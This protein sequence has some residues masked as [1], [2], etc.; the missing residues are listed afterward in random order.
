[1]AAIAGPLLKEQKRCVRFACSSQSN[2]R[3]Q[4]EEK[5]ARQPLCKHGNCGL[6]EAYPDSK[7][8]WHHLGTEFWVIPDP[9][10][11]ASAR[12]THDPV[13]RKSAALQLPELRTS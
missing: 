8:G 1:M 2:S 10:F 7:P 13:G 9:L 3:G 11:S 5:K 6:K 4:F 12:P